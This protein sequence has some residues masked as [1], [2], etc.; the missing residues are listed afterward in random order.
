[1]Y[2]NVMEIRIIKNGITLAELK[3][4]A[5]AE[6][7]DVVK[8]VVDVGQGIMAVGGELHADEEV[9]L[10]EKADSKR[11]N[12]W[13]INIYPTKSGDERIEFDSM[14][15]LKPSFGNRSRDVESVE[16]REKIKSIF[17]KLA[18]E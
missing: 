14:I 13:G 9:L 11:E 16:T 18:S 6:F 10:T 1:M 17:N 4:M 2:N 5:S 12:T 3:A 7:G 8:A 15:N